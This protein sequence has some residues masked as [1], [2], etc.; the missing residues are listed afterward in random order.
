MIP[1]EIEYNLHYDDVRGGF[2]RPPHSTIP[3]TVEWNKSQNGLPLETKNTQIK[4][5]DFQNYSACIL[6]YIASSLWI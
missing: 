2:L 6:V 5:E 4:P 3:A 1:K